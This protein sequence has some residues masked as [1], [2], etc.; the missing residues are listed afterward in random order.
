[1]I[2]T[3]TLFSP[4]GD[5]NRP[6]VERTTRNKTP[7]HGD[8]ESQRYIIFISV[9]LRFLSIWYFCFNLLSVTLWLTHWFKLVSKLNANYLKIGQFM[10]YCIDVYEVHNF[11]LWWWWQLLHMRIAGAILCCFLYF[12]ASDCLSLNS[13]TTMHCRLVGQQIVHLHSDR[14][15][16]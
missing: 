16:W 8:W 9:F 6:P 1:M 3:S 7:R 11:E 15:F 4:I 12:I 5:R 10:Y 14:Y 13:T 2:L